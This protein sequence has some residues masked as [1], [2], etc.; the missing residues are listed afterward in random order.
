MTYLRTR[1]GMPA[2]IQ[3]KEMQ[4]SPL[5]THIMTSPALSLNRLKVKFRCSAN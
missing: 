3:Q 4:N 5:S 1:T 2:E